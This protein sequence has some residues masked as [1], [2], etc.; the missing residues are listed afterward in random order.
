[1]KAYFELTKP[2]LSSLV[3]ATGGAGTLLALGAKFGN[4]V[5]PH[6]WT[7]QYAL[8]LLLSLIGLS[9]VVGAANALNCVLERDVDAL[10]ERTKNRPLV[11]G[12]LDVFSATAFGFGLAI[13]GLGILWITTNPI[14]TILGIVAFATYLGVY[15]PMKR[16]SMG[17]LFAGS[18]PGALPPL[19]GWTAVTGKADLAGWILF[20]ILF[21][22]QLPHFISISIYRGPEYA[23]AGL[24]TVGSSLGLAAANRHLLVSSA[25]LTLVGILPWGLGYAGIAYLIVSVL[26]GLMLTSFSILGFTRAVFFGSLAYL[27]LVLGTWVIEIWLFSEPHA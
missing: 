11:E 27:P 6:S 15:T 4:P 23:R 8:T 9:F 19:M 1:M 24:K 5:Q 2:R 22:W 3:I 21:F 13:L 20:G 14:T 26:F 18:I 16:L 25:I 12:R 7:W 10:M 17:A